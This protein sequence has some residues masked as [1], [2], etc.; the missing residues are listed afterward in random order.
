[1]HTLASR[2]IW[3]AGHR[4]M[5]GS[6]IVRRLATEDC[7]IVTSGRERLD[8]RRQREVED[9]IAGARPDIIVVAAGTVGGIA[10][11]ASR[12]ADFISD[13]LLI[14]TNIITAAHAAGVP[15][16]LYLSSS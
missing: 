10:A 16:L 2:R 13:N 7:E 9:F 5:V 6:A 1:M 8:L 3:V 12:P 4:G 14:A 11:N 15:R